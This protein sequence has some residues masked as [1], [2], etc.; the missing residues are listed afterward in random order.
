MQTKISYFV[1][2]DKRALLLSFPFNNPIDIIKISPYNEI[3]E[4]NLDIK[5]NGLFSI[6][7]ENSAKQKQYWYLLFPTDYADNEIDEDDLGF[8]VILVT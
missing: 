4:I 6:K 8:E 5:F 2:T 3:K 7:T 1:L